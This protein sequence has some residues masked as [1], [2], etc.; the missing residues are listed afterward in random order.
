MTTHQNFFHLI[1]LT[2]PVAKSKKAGFKSAIFSSIF[3]DDNQLILDPD[4]Y[5]RMHSLGLRHFNI[6]IIN[7]AIKCYDK[8]EF[9]DKILNVYC[10]LTVHFINANSFFSLKGFELF[11]NK[12]KDKNFELVLAFQNI[13][14]DEI[15]VRFIS[16]GIDLSGGSNTKKH[17]ISPVQHRLSLFLMCFFGTKS[18]SFVNES[19]H[20]NFQESDKKLTDYST[21]QRQD[22]V[23]DLA[24]ANEILKSR[25]LAEGPIN[26]DLI[27][28][29][30]EDEGSDSTS[31]EQSQ[32]DKRDKKYKNNNKSTYESDTSFDDE[33]NSQINNNNSTQHNN[34]L[35]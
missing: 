34:N 19:F 2:V 8:R 25:L 10:S 23:I 27:I 12:N 32:R 31:P 22:F 26:R 16:T 9:G 15:C 13:P 7:D 21:K 4:M 30:N 17:L 35:D 18:S 1:T 3:I 20:R 29:L 5:S 24:R 14:W 11:F 28:D 6:V 33:L